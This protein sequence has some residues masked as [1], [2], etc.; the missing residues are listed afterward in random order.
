MSTKP[1]RGRPRRIKAASTRLVAFR[2]SDAEFRD[3]ERAAGVLSLS[4][5]IRDVLLDAARQ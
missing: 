5:W 4:E 3:L 1:K 2:V